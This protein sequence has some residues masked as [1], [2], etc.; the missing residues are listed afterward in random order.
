MLDLIWDYRNKLDLTRL[1]M[2][3]RE[4]LCLV[5]AGR[6]QLLVAP[7]CL[8]NQKFAYSACLE[9]FRLFFEIVEGL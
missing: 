3:C 7:V 1:D 8:G 6:H 2:Q 5:S 9:M 4:M